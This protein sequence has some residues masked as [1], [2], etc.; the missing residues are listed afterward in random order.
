MANENTG[1][2]GTTSTAGLTGANALMITEVAF[3]ER[4]SNL[5]RITV[6]REGQLDVNAACTRLFGAL[7]QIKKMRPMILETFKVFDLPT[8]DDFEGPLHAA[9]YCNALW[10]SKTSNKVDTAALAADLDLSITKLKETCEM[11]VPFGKVTAEQLKRLGET[12][13][14]DGKINDVT[15]LLSI[16]RRLEPEALNRTM[17]NPSD[18]VAI[19]IALLTFQG[20]LGKKQLTPVEREEASLLRLQSLTYMLESFDVALKAAIY[21]YGETVGKQVVP[22]PY[23]DRGNRKSGK[24]ADEAEAPAADAAPKPAA[25]VT[26][27]TFVMTNPTGLPLTSPFTSDKK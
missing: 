16:L 27:D 25:T 26:P 24:E 8:F 23:A 7:P 18:L 19:E 22:S 11:L 13:G 12:G 1:S 4:E 6:F 15:L 17:L 2:S 5:R 3:R 10:L 20:A 21:F 9:H 14:Y